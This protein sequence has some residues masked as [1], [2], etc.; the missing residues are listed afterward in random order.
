MSKTTITFDIDASYNYIELSYIDLSSNTSSM[1]KLSGNSNHDKVEI[2]NFFTAILPDNIK[3]LYSS[4]SNRDTLN[5]NLRFWSKDF[6]FIQN[7]LKPADPQLISRFNRLSSIKMLDW[8]IKHNNN[9]S[10]SRRTGALFRVV[11]K[12]PVAEN[13]DTIINSNII[14]QYLSSYSN[15]INDSTQ[16]VDVL[17]DIKADLDAITG[18]T[19]T[20]AYLA[21]K[22]KIQ[23][24]IGK[25]IDSHEFMPTLFT[26][27]FLARFKSS[28]D[29]WFKQIQEK[30]SITE[31]ELSA[32]LYAGNNN[33]TAKNKK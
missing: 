21:A 30:P 18:T 9:A 11:N 22:I 24:N 33:K 16:T 4:L 29:I 28:L 14:S 1:Y 17:T 20:Q 8:A 13:I 19:A 3:T 25:P 6:E 5:N 2:N 23:N 7:A 15:K 26:P 27:K 10:M 31:D 32:T 12:D